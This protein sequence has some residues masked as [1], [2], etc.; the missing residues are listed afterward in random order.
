MPDNHQPPPPI[1][2]TLPPP[3]IPTSEPSFMFP[4]DKM[5]TVSSSE[6]DISVDEK[7]DVG[8]T[9]PKETDIISSE[10][11]DILAQLSPTKSVSSDSQP[12]AF[13]PDIK[14]S[15]FLIQKGYN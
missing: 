9:V 1:P 10:E 2:T 7:K 4:I 6:E 5:D 11:D 12:G 13:A 14:V 15:F 3:P 8:S